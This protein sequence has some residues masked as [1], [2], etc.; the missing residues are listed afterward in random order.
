LNGKKLLL[1]EQNENDVL[2]RPQPD[3]LPLGEGT[4]QSGFDFADDPAANPVAGI[5]VIG[6][7]FHT[8][9]PDVLC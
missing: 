5:S 7:S 4:A 9:E 2:A 1:V 3:L 6:E 8:V